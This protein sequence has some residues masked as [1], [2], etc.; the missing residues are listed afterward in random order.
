MNAISEVTN[1]TYVSICY[2]VDENVSYRFL[3]VLLVKKGVKLTSSFLSANAE[4][5]LWSIVMLSNDAF[6]N[7]VKNYVN[8]INSSNFT[9]PS[10]NSVTIKIEITFSQ[11]MRK[12]DR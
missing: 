6:I 7:V 1:L 5:C 3:L 4:K 11:N 8:K 12:F 9:T 2:E 10:K